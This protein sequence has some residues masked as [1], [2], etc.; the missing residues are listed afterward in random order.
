MI[1]K[2]DEN[3]TTECTSNLF[4]ENRK[5][6]SLTGVKEVI[7]FDEEKISLKTNLGPLLIKGSGL[8]MNKLDVQ[9]GEVI[10]GGFISNINY[11]NKK[12]KVKKSRNL[13]SK[14]FK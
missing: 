10:I 5:L 1:D 9:N 13:I 6:L 3:K 7:N 14:I 2:K 4:L 12:N 11:L 8:K